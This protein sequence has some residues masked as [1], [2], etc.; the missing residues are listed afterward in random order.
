MAGTK[1]QAENRLSEAKNE[2]LKRDKIREW[3]KRLNS[4]GPAVQGAFTDINNM[5]GIN[6]TGSEIT[7]SLGGGVT[8][9]AGTAAGMSSQI[10]NTLANSDRAVAQS[11]NVAMAQPIDTSSQNPSIIP[12]AASTSTVPI[13]QTGTGLGTSQP[14]WRGVLCVTNQDGAR[15]MPEIL[16]SMSPLKSSTNQYVIYHDHF[17][18]QLKDDIVKFH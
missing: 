9:P 13:N 8:A 15:A 17:R 1:F 7:T 3:I 14:V 10:S 12:A 11:A 5:S 18:M 6:A 16:V 4:A 2:F